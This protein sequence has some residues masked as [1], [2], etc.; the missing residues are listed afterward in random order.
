VSRDNITEYKTG[1]K[2]YFICARLIRKINKKHLR[3]FAPRLGVC[4]L[5]QHILYKKQ[6]TKHS[7]SCFWA[8]HMLRSLSLSAGT[9]LEPESIK[10]DNS[11]RCE[12]IMLNSASDGEVEGL[13]SETAAI[14]APAV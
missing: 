14:S 3:S 9:G 10:I 11:E 5:K 12:D 2:G 13:K 6:A 1:F 7:D 8:D 4:S